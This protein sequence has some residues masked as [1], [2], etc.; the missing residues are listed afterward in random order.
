M[1]FFIISLLFVCF[2]GILLGQ[3]V[4]VIENPLQESLDISPY[5]ELYTDTTKNLTIKSAASPKL[6]KHFIP[7]ES[8]QMSD[9]ANS[10]YWGKVKVKNPHASIS[11]FLFS[12]YNNNYV[13]FYQKD[14]NNE[15]QVKY[16]GEFVKSAAKE[17]KGLRKE[18]IFKVYLKPF[19]I[20]TLYYRVES[21]SGFK[22]NVKPEIKDPDTWLNNNRASLVIQSIFQGV[23]LIIIILCILV[24]IGNN[25]KTYL[26]YSL[27]VLSISTYFFWNY[28]FTSIYIFQKSTKFNNFLWTA[29]PLSPFFYFLFFRKFLETKKYTPKWDMVFK[30]FTYLSLT[31]FIL[32]VA[33]Q[34]ITK[35]TIYSINLSNIIILI[36][37]ILGFIF[38]NFIPKQVKLIKYALLGNAALALGGITSI[39][40]HFLGYNEYGL[41]GQLGV[42]IELVVFSM[43]LGHKV[44]LNEEN[45]RE[46]QHELIQQLEENKK[47]QNKINKELEALVHERTLEITEKN[48]KLEI[49][50]DKIASQSK[51]LKQAN[52]EIQLINFNLEEIVAERT[53]ELL[54]TKEELNLFLYRTSHDLRGPLARIEGLLQICKL[55]KE[56]PVSGYWESFDK[57]TSTMGRTLEG[58][59]TISTIINHPSDNQII[60]IDTLID[61]IKTKFEEHINNITFEYSE[62]ITFISKFNMLEFALKALIENAISFQYQEPEIKVKFLLNFENELIISVSDNGIGI[63]EQIIP[64]I[65]DMFFI[66]S[67]YSSGNGLGLFILTKVM[68]ELNGKIEVKSI[69]DQGSNFVLTIPVEVPIGSNLSLTHS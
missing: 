31:G 21:K 32:A 59:L 26:Y 25:D 47:L 23:L 62:G 2:Q 39:L 3:Q 17:V 37:L 9:K 35:Q 12:I 7:F 49:Q 24:F 1:R 14:Y 10:V 56:E 64:N 50:H 67:N 29:F 44:R 28:G 52:E 36:E 8:F 22:P 46:A 27:Y 54:H 19:E 13:E 6:E 18:N 51:K 66:G 5:I 34:L 68:K 20:T 11:Y 42:I 60:E 16:G 38:L 65:F 43:G 69:V 40:W 15:F 30:I 55:D 4:V 53:K 33:L 45:K 57:V 48:R 61:N 63:D 41:F 58:L